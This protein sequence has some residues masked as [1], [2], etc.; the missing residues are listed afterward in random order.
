MASRSSCSGVQPVRTLPFEYF[1]TYPKQSTLP[2]FRSARACITGS[3]HH[4]IRILTDGTN[5]MNSPTLHE[6][7]LIMAPDLSRSIAPP[8]FILVFRNAALAQ[9]R[10]AL[11][12][13]PATGRRST[14]SGKN[15]AS[16]IPGCG[17]QD[18]LQTAGGF[19]DAYA[20]VAAGRSL[21][22]YTTFQ[23]LVHRGSH[24]NIQR[25]SPLRPAARLFGTKYL[26]PP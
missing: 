26:S 7:R 17:G 25:G 18:S 11:T 1:L 14:Q 15:V 21:C 8:K 12:L 5:H 10:S 16:V 6:S 2:L 20:S 3:L 22:S 23:L 19:R 4:S 24:V 13:Y 9:L